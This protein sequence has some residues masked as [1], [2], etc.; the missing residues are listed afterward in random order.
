MCRTSVLDQVY[1][2]LEVEAPESNRAVDE[3]RGEIL[4]D[5][6]GKPFQAFFH[7]SCGGSTELPSH[8]WKSSTE[9]DVFGCVA[10]P[11]CDGDPHYKWRLSISYATIRA[12]LRKAGIRVRDI[13]KIIIVQKS[14]SGRADVWS[15]DVARRGGGGGESLSSGFGARKFEE[16]THHHPESGQIQCVF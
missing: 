2:G 10:D 15:A 7:S 11:F 13:K 9:S 5:E 3:S 6:A 1:G 12:R 16:Y 8:V 4:V 14:D